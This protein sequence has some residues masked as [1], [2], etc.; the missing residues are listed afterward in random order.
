MGSTNCY[1]RFTGEWFD[2]LTAEDAANVILPDA[3]WVIQ[4]SIGRKVV[5][6]FEKRD[7]AWD[8]EDA[9]IKEL[10]QLLTEE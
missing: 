6:A 7:A 10:E 2:E 9:A 5:E 8:L 1:P 4:E 3:P